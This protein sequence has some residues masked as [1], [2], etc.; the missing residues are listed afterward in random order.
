MKEEEIS[1]I[2]ESI[3]EKLGEESAALIADDLGILIT[4]NKEVQELIA[5]QN[6]E[7]TTLKDT[8]EKLVLANGNLLKQVPMGKSEPVKEESS[9]KK[10]FNF[11]DMFDKHGNFRTDI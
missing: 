7:I 4:Q 6:E 8:N 2:S 3:K 9:E 1:K 5:K 10:S 11:K